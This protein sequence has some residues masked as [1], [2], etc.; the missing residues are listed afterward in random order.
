KRH[1]EEV[2]GVGQRRARPDQ[3]NALLHELRI[4]DVFFCRFQHFAADV[5][6]IDLKSR[7]SAEVSEGPSEATSEVQYARFGKRAEH[8]QQEG[9]LLRIMCL[10]GAAR[11]DLANP[12]GASELVPPCLVRSLRFQFLG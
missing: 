9:L 11:F 2:I 3:P 10:L 1:I 8:A 5:A 4:A 12:D 7:D 6:A